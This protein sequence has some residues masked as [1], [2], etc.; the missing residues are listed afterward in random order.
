MVRAYER[1][2]IDAPVRSA[3]RAFVGITN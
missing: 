1:M 3:H 2:I